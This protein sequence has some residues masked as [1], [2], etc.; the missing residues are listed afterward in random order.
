VAH[1][2]SRRTSTSSPDS[3][4]LELMESL[5]PEFK[6][7]CQKLY[8]AIQ[9]DRGKNGAWD[10]YQKLIGGHGAMFG[11]SL[12]TLLA[13]ECPGRK[14]A[15]LS[16]GWEDWKCGWDGIR[17]N[18]VG[19]RRITSKLKQN[20]EWAAT[21]PAPLAFMGADR[22][23]ANYKESVG[24]AIRMRAFVNFVELGIPVL[25]L[26]CEMQR[27]YLKE[28]RESPQIYRQNEATIG[29]L[30]F[31]REK[32]GRCWFERLAVLLNV[33][34]DLSAI[35]KHVTAESLRRM[36]GRRFDDRAPRKSGQIK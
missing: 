29:I 20:I 7:W 34:R 25:E 33:S 10:S 30:R 32:T 8:R 17:R 28:V 31:V 4:N 11:S 21:G 27:E 1:L 14:T 9:D 6:S 22:W 3:E 24:A 19:L 23:E 16:D 5:P 35:K 26:Y 18:A 12:L 2:R 13:A 36:W 15:A